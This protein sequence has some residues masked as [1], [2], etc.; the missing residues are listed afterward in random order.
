MFDVFVAELRCPHCGQINPTTADTAMQTHLREDA[1]GSGLGV[2]FVFDPRDLTTRSILD[3]GYLLIAEPPPSG[4]IRL[5]DV[6]SCPQCSTE[7]WVMVTIAEGWIERIEPVV[8]TRAVLE[9]ANFISDVNAELEAKGFA[10]A[11][12]DAAGGVGSVDVLRRHLP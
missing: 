11:G 6:W 4:P 10:G 9:T 1:D 7:Q 2:G 12:A 3:S 8:L 5:L